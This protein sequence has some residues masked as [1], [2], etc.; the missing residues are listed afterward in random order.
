MI[1]E[2]TLSI[3]QDIG[4]GADIDSLE[5][6]II[7]FE[8]ASKLTNLERFRYNYDILKRLLKELKPDSIAFET[9]DIEE[10]KEDKF[11]YLFEQYGNIRKPVA[12]GTIDM[13]ATSDIREKINNAQDSISDILALVEVQGLDCMCTYKDGYICKAYLIGES[14]R[15]KDIT[16][17]ICDKV[18]KRIKELS[19]YELV[20][21]R[22]KLVINNKRLEQI[23]LHTETSLNQALRCGIYNEDINVIFN[24]IISDNI[25]FKTQWEKMEFMKQLDIETVPYVLVRGIDETILPQAI[26]DIYNTFKE[27]EIEYSTYGFEIRLNEYL[28]NNTGFIAILDDADYR[29]VYESTVKS[30]A[31]EDSTGI[32]ILKIVDTKCNK[33]F[34]ISSIEVNDIY[35]LEKLGISIGSKVHFRVIEGKAILI[36]NQR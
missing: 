23:S 3:L 33:E 7:D 4:F 24:D 27:I 30:V 10:L 17:F 19:K 9:K 15:Y 16:E 35:L 11:A 22:G 31:T 1:N 32:Q 28:D 2:N 13:L 21:L 36:D 6:Y 20:E 18:P 29:K 14:K 25:T 12:Y 34:S 26:Y 8:E 5:S